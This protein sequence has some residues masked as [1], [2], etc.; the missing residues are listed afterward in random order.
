MGRPDVFV[1][2]GMAVFRGPSD[3][4]N[5]EEGEPGAVPLDAAYGAAVSGE[6]PD[7]PQDGYGGED[8]WSEDER[9]GGE[10]LA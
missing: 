9:R 7:V 1:R 10:A 8:V 6:T 5:G 2:C 4:A 3:D